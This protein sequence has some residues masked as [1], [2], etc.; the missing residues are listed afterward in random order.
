MAIQVIWKRGPPKV[1]SKDPSTSPETVSDVWG[2][3]DDGVASLHLR[4]G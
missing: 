2:S 4:S 1:E 3:L